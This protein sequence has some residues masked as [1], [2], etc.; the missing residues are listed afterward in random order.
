MDGRGTGAIAALSMEQGNV[1]ANTADGIGSCSIYYMHGR[2]AGPL[3]AWRRELERARALGFSHVA[4]SPLFAPGPNG[5]VFLAGNF[6]QAGSWLQAPRP[7]DQVAASLADL[8]RPL[9]LG[10]LLDIV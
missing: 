2:L 4:V 1:V 6:E 3:A 5:D 9:G 7:V 10:L 8:C